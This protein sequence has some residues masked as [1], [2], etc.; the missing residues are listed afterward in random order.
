MAEALKFLRE[1]EL[2]EAA[3]RLCEERRL[4]NSANDEWDP[5]GA[6][7]ARSRAKQHQYRVKQLIRNR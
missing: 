5:E 4:L 1:N 2:E 7:S 3:D 6:A